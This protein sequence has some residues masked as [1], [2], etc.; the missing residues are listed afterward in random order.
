MNRVINNETDVDDDDFDEGNFENCYQTE[1]E[2]E[3][4]ISDSDNST[5]EEESV[6]VTDYFTQGHFLDDTIDIDNQTDAD[7]EIFWSDEEQEDEEQEDEE[8]EDKELETHHMD[9]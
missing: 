6:N 9:E 4:D 2:M 1:V 3:D 5:S 7:V 8:Q